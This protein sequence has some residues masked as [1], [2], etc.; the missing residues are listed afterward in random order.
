MVLKWKE[1]FF[2][3]T[4][5][6]KSPFHC[7]WLLL[8]VGRQLINLAGSAV[9]ITLPS[10]LKLV[11]ISIYWAPNVCWVLVLILRVDGYGSALK[12]LVG[13]VLTRRWREGSSGDNLESAI[14]MRSVLYVS[15]FESALSLCISTLASPPDYPPLFIF[16]VSILLIQQ[17]ERIYL[18][19]WK[20]FLSCVHDASSL[21]FQIIIFV[22]R[23]CWG[24]NKHGLIALCG[25]QNSNMVLKIPSLTPTAHVPWISPGTVNVMNFKLCYMAWAILREGYYSG[26]PDLITTAL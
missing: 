6:S 20:V 2:F 8:G 1:V 23:Q 13:Y 9:C 18:L 21:K 10:Y 22:V 14:F 19:L 24:K 26:E 17:V 11:W 15:S 25:R 4:G 12:K 16:M 3:L 5:S 7:L